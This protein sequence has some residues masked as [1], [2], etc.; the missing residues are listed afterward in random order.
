MERNRIMKDQANPGAKHAPGDIAI[1]ANTISARWKKVDG[2]L[3]ILDVMAKL[4]KDM[5]NNV[6][7]E[8]WK[9]VMLIKAE[10]AEADYKDAAS[11][12]DVAEEPVSVKPEALV[13]P[14]P[15]R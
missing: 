2:T 1:S 11:S 5:Y 7:I 12:A 15:S 6:E 9:A 3:K 10:D 14:L 13:P 8:E 4:D